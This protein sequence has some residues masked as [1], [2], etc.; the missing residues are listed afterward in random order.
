MNSIKKQSGVAAIWFVFVFIALAGFTALGVEGTRYMNYKARLGDALETSSLLLAADQA[1]KELSLRGSEQVKRKQASLDLV[2]NTIKSYLKDTQDIPKTDIKISQNGSKPEFSYKVA[3]VTRHDSFMHM[4]GAP[5]FDK[6]QDVSNFASAA[7]HSAGGGNGGAADVVLVVD[8]SMAMNADT[9]TYRESAGK[10]RLQSAKQAVAHQ[11]VRFFIEQVRRPNET[12][13]SKIGRVAVVPYENATRNR[14]RGWTEENPSPNAAVMCEN[15][16]AFKSAGGSGYDEFNWQAELDKNK[17]KSP[18][19]LSKDTALKMQPYMAKSLFTENKIGRDTKVVNDWLPFN[20]EDVDIRRTIERA[21]SGRVRNTNADLKVDGSQAIQRDFNR[22]CRGN[23][24]TIGFDHQWNIGPLDK[25]QM[26][27]DPFTNRVRSFN[28]GSAWQTTVDGQSEQYKGSWTSSF[29]GILGGVEQIKQHKG[30]RPLMVV[31]IAGGRDTPNVDTQL[32][33]LATDYKGQPFKQE[34]L[35]KQLI[36]GKQG[37]FSQV[38]A[39]YPYAQ[40]VL[41]RFQPNNP[42]KKLTLNY[43]DAFDVIYDV[44][45]QKASGNNMTGECK[46]FDSSVNNDYQFDAGMMGDL[47]AK[48]AELLGV[49]KDAY[50]AGSAEVGSLDNRRKK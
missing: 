30:D 34:L 19:E 47:E 8:H 15:H 21:L 4:S 10:T 35:T 11:I 25:Q 7:K 13:E 37:L 49:A 41:L 1:E 39:K 43:Q 17:G 2:N 42:S 46:N 12:D 29:Q 24:M 50:G 16:L 3:A 38:K 14:M 9:C 36:S 44:K 33:R 32:T 6:Q 18:E 20:A 5:S 28:S 48:V 23:M 27:Y 45:Y 31:L 40:F 22:I 26:K